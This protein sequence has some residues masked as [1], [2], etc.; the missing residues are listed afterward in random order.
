M[1]NPS[2]RI[3][4]YTKNNRLC[5]KEL[6]SVKGT[7]IKQNPNSK[8]EAKISISDG[9]IPLNSLMIFF[10]SEIKVIK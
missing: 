7:K 10:N 4:L 8:K 2:F 9:S 3:L 1:K 6:G 5:K